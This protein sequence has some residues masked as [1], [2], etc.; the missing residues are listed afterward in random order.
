MSKINAYKIEEKSVN[1]FRSI[2]SDYESDGGKSA[3]F[4]EL[5]GRDYGIDGIVEIFEKIA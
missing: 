4:R 5:T 1:I 3:T 2:I